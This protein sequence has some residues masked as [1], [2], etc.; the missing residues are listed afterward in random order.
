MMMLP[1]LLLSLAWA[2]ERQQP[3]PAEFQLG[4]VSVTGDPPG[5]DGL[6]R[7]Y[8]LSPTLNFA[9]A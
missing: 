6:R 9:R 4:A 2:T 7:A 3:P 1:L 8:R 5:L